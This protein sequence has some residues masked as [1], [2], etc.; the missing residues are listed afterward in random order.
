MYRC[1]L[2]ESSIV[3]L[4]Q[5]AIDGLSV[6]TS[7]ANSVGV[8]IQVDGGRLKAD[9]KL[10]W[11]LYQRYANR[12]QRARPDHGTIRWSQVRRQDLHLNC[13]GRLRAS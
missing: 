3:Q 10:H 6:L 11:W 9:P 13:A 5:V 2:F 7:T 8:W 12:L 1:S 4:L